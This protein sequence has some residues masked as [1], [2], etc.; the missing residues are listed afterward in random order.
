M[1]TINLEFTPSDI[2]VH[3]NT[4]YLCNVKNKQVMIFDYSDPELAIIIDNAV[5]SKKQKLENKFYPTGLYVFNERLYIIDK[6]NSC[7]HLFNI[8]ENDFMQPIIHTFIGSIKTEVS[9][10]Y[11]CIS[12]TFIYTT[13][14]NISGAIQ[15]YYTNYTYFIYTTPHTDLSSIKI[16]TPNSTYN[17]DANKIIPYGSSSMTLRYFGPPYKNISYNNRSNYSMMFSFRRPTHIC[18]WNNTFFVADTGNN[19]IR[20]FN[21]TTFKYLY[22]I[23]TK[24]EGN[25]DNQFNQPSGMCVINDHLYIA[26]T[27]NQRIKVY[28]LKN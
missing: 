6:N 4:I 11:L 13:L 15:I 1:D 26:D 25:R 24:E 21:A 9:L 19:C 18:L 23:G 16:Y 2:C 3:F 27:N 8:T 10:L 22:T 14:Y 20:A 17:L 28:K 5:I 12:S 7:I